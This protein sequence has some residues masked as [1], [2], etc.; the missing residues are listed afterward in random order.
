M[1]PDLEELRL[2]F[3]CAV[4]VV[5]TVISRSGA[6]IVLDAGWRAMGC[7]Y[8]PPVPLDPRAHIRAL[9]DEHTTLVWDGK[10]P[11]LGSHVRLRPSQNRTTFNLHRVVWLEKEDCIVERLQIATGSS[12]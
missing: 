6:H 5:G 2:P 7:E 12:W 10:P 3:R 9:G 1:E 4:C 8:G 11:Q